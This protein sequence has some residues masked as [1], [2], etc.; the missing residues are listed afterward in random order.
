MRGWV[1][2]LGGKL[3]IGMRTVRAHD[4]WWG[5]EVLIGGEMLIGCVEV[6]RVLKGCVKH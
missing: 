4:L 3:V 1:G 5:G 2:L 6:G